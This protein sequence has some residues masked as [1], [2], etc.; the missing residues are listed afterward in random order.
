MLDIADQAAAEK[1]AHTEMAFLFMDHTCRAT[2]VLRSAGKRF[3]P[4]KCHS[5]YTEYYNGTRH[6]FRFCRSSGPV[7]FGI[8]ILRNPSFGFLYWPF[9]W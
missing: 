2:D 1:Q 3:Q 5:I 8:H 7:G 4:S 9:W 6:R